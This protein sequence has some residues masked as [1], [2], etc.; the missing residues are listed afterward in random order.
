MENNE[1]AAKG[2][3]KVILGKEVKAL[4]PVVGKDENRLAL[5][6]CLIKGDY[7]AATDGKILARMTLNTELSKDEIPTTIRTGAD[8]DR[9]WVSSE[10][11]KKALGNI[12][13]KNALPAIQDNV[14]LYKENGTV[15]FQVLDGEF[16]PISLEERKSEDFAG[17]FPDVE[18][19][20]E[21]NGEAERKKIKIAAE[22]IIKL[23]DVVKSLGKEAS[24][25]LEI[26]DERH[27]VLY[28]IDEYGAE[29]VNGAF[30][31]LK[32]E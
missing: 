20:L 24:I 27:P 14:Y 28:R 26:S 8:S 22:T 15:K 3:E 5:K 12:S 4:L 25:V 16:N 17:S 32:N 10:V 29:K 18:K 13:K 7:I 23:A 2:F 11:L 21:V 6:G 1:K 30:M 9:I 19:I 31:P